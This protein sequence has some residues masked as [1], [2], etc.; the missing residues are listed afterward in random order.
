MQKS[1]KPLYKS[2]SKVS[3]L[4]RAVRI[5]REQKLKDEYE[6]LSSLL[7]SGKICN[8]KKRR[9][10]DDFKISIRLYHTELSFL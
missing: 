6:R 2:R 5:E 8:L 9:F 4:T 3:T 1:Q 10:E 7:V